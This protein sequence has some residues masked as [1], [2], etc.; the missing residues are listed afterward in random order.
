MIILQ[1]WVNV[2]WRLCPK[3]HLWHAWH[4]DICIFLNINMGVK[5]SVRTSGMQLV[6]L[7]I[8]K[9]LFYDQNWKF[10]NSWFLLCIFRNFFVNFM[11]LCRNSKHCWKTL[12]L[13]TS[14]CH[15]L[16]I[17]IFHFWNVFVMLGVVWTFLC[18]EVNIKNKSN[19]WISIF[20][21]KTSFGFRPDHL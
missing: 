11:R 13:N 4:Y 3:C 18:T 17:K 10:C 12:N 6:I 15:T 9:R 20:V 14:H 8:L 5:W 7:N 16:R 2:E 1:F 19:I 21:F